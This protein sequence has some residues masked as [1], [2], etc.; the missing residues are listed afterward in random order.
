MNYHSQNEWQKRIRMAA[1]KILGD[2][3]SKCGFDDYRVLQIDHI[4]G[5][6]SK[7]RQIATRNFNKI[8]IESAL[9]NEGKYQILCANCNWIKRY[10]RNEHKNRFI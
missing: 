10:E 9:K 7:D 4:L 2:K 6:G 1:L 3:C 8:V 5:G